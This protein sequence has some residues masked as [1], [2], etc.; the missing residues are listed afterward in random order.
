MPKLQ[1]LQ[2]LIPFGLYPVL[3]ADPIWPVEGHSQ[4]CSQFESL[5]LIAIREIFLNP[6][7][8]KNKT[9]KTQDW[10]LEDLFGYPMSSLF[11]EANN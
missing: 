7:N 3:T 4:S 11:R 9:C 8:G 10:V 6:G 2:G 5:N 1:E